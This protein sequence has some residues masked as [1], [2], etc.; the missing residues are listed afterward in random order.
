MAKGLKTGG[1]VT[2][3]PSKQTAT[4]RQALH[5]AF[6]ELGGVAALVEW[7]RANPTEFYRIW[8]K[9]LPKELSIQEP[10]EAG[11]RCIVLPR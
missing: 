8:S 11:S 9:M 10:P 3:T 2:G 6:D 4:V 7:G 1:R 5:N